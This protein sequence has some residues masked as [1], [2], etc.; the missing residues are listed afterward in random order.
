MKVQV[1]FKLPSICKQRCL[2]LRFSCY[3]AICLCDK[4][5]ISHLLL[6][7]IC[8]FSLFVSLE[9]FRFFSFCLKCVKMSWIHIKDWNCIFTE[10]KANEKAQLWIDLFDV[11]D[12]NTKFDVLR[13]KLHEH[14]FFAQF[15]W[16]L[17]VTHS[18]NTKIGDVPIEFHEF[19]DKKLMT[20]KGLEPA[21]QPPL[22]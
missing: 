4:G 12:V 13:A 8:S 21:T 19:S 2:D 6:S 11:L 14:R 10:Q 16:V 1:S 20:L 7:N 18:K 5:Q 22:V 15:K 9:I 3:L 17:N